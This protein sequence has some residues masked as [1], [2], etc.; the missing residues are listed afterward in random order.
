MTVSITPQLRV[1]LTLQCYYLRK[2]SQ[3][4]KAISLNSIKPCDGTVNIAGC[5]PSNENKCMSP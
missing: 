1:T 3:R 2:H 5:S 4:E